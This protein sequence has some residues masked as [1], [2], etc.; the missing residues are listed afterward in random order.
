M[1]WQCSFVCDIEIYLYLHLKHFLLG[2]WRT[3]QHL[4]FRKCVILVIF[5]QVKLFF[6]E[7][8]VSWLEAAKWIFSVCL[9]SDEDLIC[10][11]EKCCFAV[12]CLPL[13]IILLTKYK[14]MCKFIVMLY[15]IYDKDCETWTLFINISSFDNII[16]STFLVIK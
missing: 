11:V 1:L 5:C 2:S 12:K 16:Q 9:F 7:H 14:L 6:R 8:Y 4:F 10:G 13:V 3:A 15:N